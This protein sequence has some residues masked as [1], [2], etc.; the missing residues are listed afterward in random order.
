[1]S[2]Q[3]EQLSCSRG[4]RTLFSD[5]AFTL[6]SG[7]AL[8]IQGDNGSGKTSLLRLLCGLSRPEQGE[9][10]WHGTR[11]DRIRTQF[12]SSLLYVGHA[13]GVKDDLLAWENIVFG[14][15]LGVPNSRDAAYRSL[16]MMGLANEVDLPI[17]TLSQG[18]RKRVALARLHLAG[19]RTIWI[20]DEPFT[21]LDGAAVDLVR[22]LLESHRDRGG[23]VIYTTHQETRLADATTLVL[24]GA[25]ERAR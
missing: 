5:L 8:L 15:M 6:G 24:G 14:A 19:T 7:S 21:A 11:I 13:E 18:Q 9:I 23:I 16:E 4:G 1:M 22:G 2:L 3:C 20:L 17:R 12:N 25:A 10:R